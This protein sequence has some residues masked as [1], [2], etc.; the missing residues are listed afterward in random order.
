M[1]EE[2]EKVGFEAVCRDE[3]TVGEV[4]VGVVG[5][6]PDCLGGEYL[7]FLLSREEVAYKELDGCLLGRWDDSGNYFYGMVGVVSPL[8]CYQR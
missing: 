1:C 2:G 8:P 6:E 4:L 5:A 3:L 7:C